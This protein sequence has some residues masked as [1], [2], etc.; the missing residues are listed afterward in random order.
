[1]N[2]GLPKPSL[3]SYEKDCIKEKQELV[4]KVLA[5]KSKLKQIKIVIYW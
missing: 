4:G 2:S 1:M 3:D 5:D